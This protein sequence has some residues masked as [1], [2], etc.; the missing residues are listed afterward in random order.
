MQAVLLRCRPLAR[1]HFGKLAPDSNTSLNTAGAWLP[2][3]TLFSA[4]ANILADIAPKEMDGLLD[5]F[6][7]RKVSIS[8]GFYALET[9]EKTIFFLPKPA[10]YGLRVEGEFKAYNRV[11]L[12]SKTVWEKG[13]RYEDWE[14]QCLFLQN[15]AA[16]VDRDELPVAFFEGKS[17]T[18]LKK[19]AA[20][21]ALFQEDDFPH[22]KNHTQDRLNRYYSVTSTGIADN[23][24]F[25]PKSSVH[26]YFLLEVQPEFE[27]SPE[28]QLIQAAIRMLP[29]RGVGG[30][31]SAGCGLYES[32][33]FQAFTPPNTGTGHYCSVALTV[34]ANPAELRRLECYQVTT[35]GGRRYG[36]DEK[37]FSFIR[38]MA[39]GA[40]ATGKVDGHVVKIGKNKGHDVWRYGKAFCLETH[41]V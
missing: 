22:V 38:M 27:A 10:Q 24:L 36:S 26:M 21:L 9:G 14:K 41:P 40:Y 17:E 4:L 1:F 15:G 8:S 35:R 31:R 32:A 19:A 2:S 12:I 18:D 13:L 5:C 16:V 7:T 23:S 6:F 33:E 25:L 28:F 11:K 20:Q 29:D 34:P 3:D 37:R 30:E 39:E